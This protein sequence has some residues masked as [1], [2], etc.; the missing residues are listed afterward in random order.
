MPA[1]TSPESLLE[2]VRKSGLIKRPA[3][4]AHLE[5]TPPPADPEQAMKAL[6]EAGLVTPFQS[7]FLLQGRHKGLLLG[8]YKVLRPLAKGGMGLVYLA[9][10][11][12]MRR[13]VAL[14]VCMTD[15]KGEGVVERFQREA[16]ALAAVDHPNIVRVHDSGR[17]GNTHFLVM[18]YVEGKS[19]DQIL[20]VKGCFPMR[21]AVGYALQTARG[22]EHAHERG[23]IHRDIKPANLILDNEGTIKILDMGLARFFTD[24]E[25]DLTARLGNGILGSPD[26]I[27]PEQ[28]IN[29]LDI[30]SD[31]YSLGA[32]IHA[33]ISGE[34]PFPDTTAPRKLLAHQLRHP[35]PLNKMNP[36]IPQGLAMA[37]LRMLAKNPEDRFQT[38][39][40]VIV[41]LS[42]YGPVEATA[43]RHGRSEASS[44]ARPAF[45]TRPRRRGRP[46]GGSSS[47]AWSRWPA[48]VCGD[49]LRSPLPTDAIASQR[50]LEPGL[51]A[52]DTH[53]RS[54]DARKSLRVVGTPRQR[55]NGY[56]LPGTPAGDRRGRR[57]QGHDRSGGR[58]RLY[59]ARGSSRECAAGTR[60]HHPEPR[61]GV[62]LRHPL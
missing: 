20:G 43:P 28:A 6:I 57:G 34:P 26:Y 24:V 33:L 32:T 29:Q 62:G 12:E 41:A 56:R 51:D 15:R 35:T 21:Q 47:S 39:G 52:N 59:S 58:Q 46:R 18:E 31:I 48:S 7:R 2:I 40:E 3:L 14:K 38:P 10:H 4:D 11:T 55:R 37:V 5:T 25:D 9:E 45:R 13:R 30:R 49:C 42:P 22:L 53:S 16:R 61:A 8:P 19:L 54:C 44:P 23:L 17:D 36:S 27:S 50:G 1:P 60:L